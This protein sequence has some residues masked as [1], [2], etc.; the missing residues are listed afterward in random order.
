MSE[1]VFR[2]LW[3]DIY[4]LDPVIITTAVLT[5]FRWSSFGPTTVTW[6]GPVSYPLTATSTSLRRGSSQCGRYSAMYGPWC[7]LDLSK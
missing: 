7:M 2:F 5:P 4:K 1:L 3:L 6:P